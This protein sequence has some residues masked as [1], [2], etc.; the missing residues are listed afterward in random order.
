MLKVLKGKD[1]LYTQGNKQ[2]LSPTS[3]Q[4]QCKSKDNTIK[5]IRVRKEVSSGILYPVKI[6]FKDKGKTKTFLD[7]QEL[8]VFR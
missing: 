6:S 2:I 5:K 8:F 7:T 3:Y 4:K 1:T